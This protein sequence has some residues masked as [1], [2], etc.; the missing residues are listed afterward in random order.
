MQNRDLAA[1][2]Y[3]TF[4][5]GMLCLLLSLFSCDPNFDPEDP[6]APQPAVVTEDIV[7]R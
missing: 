5:V 4:R 7:D 3:L 2:V 1:K 6:P